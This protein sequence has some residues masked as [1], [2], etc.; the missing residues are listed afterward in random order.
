MMLAAVDLDGTILAC[1]SVV[2]A[3]MSALH[4]S[5]WRVVVLTGVADGS[6]SD[7]AGWEAKRAKLKVAGVTAWDELVLIGAIGDALAEAKARWCEANGACLLI[8]NSKANA[9]AAV[10]AGVFTLVPWGSR[11]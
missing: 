7:E 6:S 5:G 1:P 10:Q 9:Q 2:G 4:A 3:L 8:D 11:V